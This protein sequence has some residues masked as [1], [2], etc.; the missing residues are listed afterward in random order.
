MPERPPPRASLQP[1]GCP[2]TSPALTFF[3][4]NV[5][6]SMFRGSQGPHKT[7]TDWNQNA[8][9]KHT[10]FG[11]GSI[12]T[13]CDVRL[14]AARAEDNGPVPRRLSDG[15][16]GSPGHGHQHRRQQQQLLAAPHPVGVPPPAIRPAR[17][18]PP[19]PG[20][21]RG[22]PFARA[23][24]VRVRA[25]AHTYT[26]ARVSRLRAFC[27]RVRRAVRSKGGHGPRVLLRACG[28]V[29]ARGEGW[30]GAPQSSALPG[31]SVIWG[32]I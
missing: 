26:Q 9:S 12:T 25:P 10:P 7:H 31:A 15:A 32:G 29:R 3:A 30:S 27:A 13:E 1:P 22:P 6:S 4:I 11:E 19:T 20:G 8:H 23:P 14:A 17:F 21:V 5:A 2:L 16:Q 28:Q 18:P 24:W